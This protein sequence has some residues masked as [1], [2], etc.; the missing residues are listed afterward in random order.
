MIFENKVINLPKGDVLSCFVFGE[1]ELR[2]YLKNDG[3]KMKKIKLGNI[4]RCENQK[5]EFDCEFVYQI[6][7]KHL[8][9][10]INGNISIVDIDE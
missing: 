10:C 8:C 7:K 5:S 3:I 4:V 6:S 1:N 9:K 2:L